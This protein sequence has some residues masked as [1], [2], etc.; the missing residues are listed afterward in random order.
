MDASRKRQRANTKGEAAQ[1]GSAHHPYLPPTSMDNAYP[2]A[3]NYVLPAPVPHAQQIRASYRSGS[4]PQMYPGATPH[5]YPYAHHPPPPIPQEHLPAY[6]DAVYAADDGVFI[7]TLLLHA[8]TALP[9]IGAQ[10]RTKYNDL[11]L[12]HQ[13]RS[14]TVQQ[15]SRPINPASL[16]QQPRPI[17]FD[18]YSKDVWHAINDDYDHLS[19]S[20]QY[21]KAFDVFDE[22][23]SIIKAV[24]C[25][26]VSQPASF[27]TKRSGLETLRK[28][29]KTI[30]LSSGDTFG[31]E[32]QKQFQH[33]CTLEDAMSA[34]VSAMND[35]EFR[36]MCDW[37]D[38][39]ST[40]MQKMHELKRLADGYR[41]F[42][43][44][45]EVFADLGGESEKDDE[46]EEYDDSQEAYGADENINTV[47][48]G[49]QFDNSEEEEEYMDCWDSDGAQK[50]DAKSRRVMAKFNRKQARRGA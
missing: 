48:W 35:T 23:T 37:N 42:G 43:E 10:L 9:G 24:K 39:R 38:G 34:I 1:Y 36:D 6:I 16:Q 20:K 47:G 26:C 13:S 11:C 27:G 44:L 41:L 17:G 5:V 49:P 3:G 31:H 22:V 14:L 25:E 15:Q 18:H 50:D 30:C 28:I 2:V 4:P 7:K 46:E 45:D 33:D 19:S 40:F 32:L 8:A 29:A 12:Q 21:E